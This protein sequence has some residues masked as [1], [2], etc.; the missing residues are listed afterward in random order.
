LGYFPTTNHDELARALAKMDADPPQAISLFAD[1]FAIENRNT[2][3]DFAM[4]HRLPVVSGWPI[5]AKSGALCTY[6]P[7]LA[8]SYRRLAY[9][10]DRVLKGAKPADLPIEQPT[11][12]ELVVN[13]RTAKTLGLTVPTALLA[14]ADEVIE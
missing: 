11:T 12:F 8:A 3:I 13:Q 4:A 10:V 1:G 7:R 9:Y 5:F 2:I 14:R 6:G